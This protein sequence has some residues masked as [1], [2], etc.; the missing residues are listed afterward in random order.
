MKRST[1]QVSLCE[2]LHKNVWK[3]IVCIFISWSASKRS[4][5]CASCSPHAWAALR[6]VEFDLEKCN[7]VKRKAHLRTIMWNNVSHF[8][9]NHFNWVHEQT[10]RLHHRG[11]RKFNTKSNWTEAWKY[12][13]RKSK[14]HQKSCPVRASLI[15][16]NHFKFIRQSSEI[17][18]KSIR[19]SSTRFI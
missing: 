10:T 14:I 18:S 12:E 1:G 5:R 6:A 16:I 2:T 8:W 15:I 13:S 9:Y 11:W 7:E 17:R 3:R 4:S 19:D